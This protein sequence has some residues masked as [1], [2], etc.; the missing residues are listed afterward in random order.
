MSCTVALPCGHQGN[1]E[2][3]PYF[4]G[5]AVPPLLGGNRCGCETLPKPA[6]TLHSALN[7]LLT[8][9]WLHCRR[10]SE[11]AFNARPSCFAACGATLS[12][13]TSNKIVALGQPRFL[14]E[15]T[16]EPASGNSLAPML[17]AGNSEKWSNFANFFL[18]NISAFWRDILKSR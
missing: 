2:G 1:L 16:N 11:E 4:A 13:T 15:A 18:L 5:G 10:K 3:P 12:H 6:K 7:L 8:L 14:L 17:L 9:K